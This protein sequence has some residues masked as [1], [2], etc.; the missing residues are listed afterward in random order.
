MNE[1]EKIAQMNEGYELAFIK[2]VVERIERL[3]YSHRQFS[4]VV[5]GQDSGPRIWQRVRNPRPGEKRRNLTLEECARIATF[6][7]E[8]LSDLILRTYKERRIEMED[9]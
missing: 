9:Q 5:F 6:F 3:G 8:D 4:M 2:S 1:Q 7:K